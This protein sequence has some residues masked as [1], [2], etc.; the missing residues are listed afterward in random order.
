MFTS[1]DD[2]FSVPLPT[3]SSYLAINTVSVY[4][5]A[6]EALQSFKALSTRE[7]EGGET[8]KAF[9]YTGNYLNTTIM[10]TALTLGVGKSASAH[11]VEVGA[12]SYGSLGYG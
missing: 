12:A 7:K 6:Q 9:I 2:P 11:L 5:A 10:P 8:P 4:A 1:A 3:F